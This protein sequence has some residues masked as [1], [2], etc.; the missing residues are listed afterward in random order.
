[1]KKMISIILALSMVLSLCVGVHAE[2]LGI[3]ASV[4]GGSIA[5]EASK[6]INNE[7]AEKYGTEERVTYVVASY[8][9]EGRLSGTYVTDTSI[10]NYLSL[11]K[12]D[13][14]DFSE[15]KLADGAAKSKVFA[16]KDSIEKPEF[17]NMPE[18]ITLHI[19]GASTTTDSYGES[20]YPQQGWGY[21]FS[22]F[23]NE[24]VTINN[25]ARGGWSLKA[26]QE[27]S[28]KNSKETDKDNSVYSNMMDKVEEN[29]FVII[30]STG[31]N[32]QYQKGG[33]RYDEAGNLVYTWRES[34]SEYKMR[35]KNTIR[36]IRSKGATPIVLIA[37][38]SNT[39]DAFGYPEQTESEY[40]TVIRELSEEMGFILIN[41][42]TAFYDYV[43]SRGFNY[44]EFKKYFVMSKLAKEWYA[45]NDHVGSG[46]QEKMDEDDVVHFTT[47]G[48]LTVGEIIANGIKETGCG[49]VYYM[50]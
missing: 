37:M 11:G 47:I 15:I 50:K 41:H 46:I 29:D 49:L 17:L 26:L 5:A 38:G 35:L 10:N 40:A 9:S 43:K 7:S 33:D 39:S 2:I 44:K 14:V 19:I 23:F 27:A 12:S 8:D 20:S 25:V 3:D 13:T 28:V 32:E 36:E 31:L 34:A 4:S 21:Q 30:S 16:I 45:E 22:R 6:A 42:R 1:M 24:N 48:A 18:K